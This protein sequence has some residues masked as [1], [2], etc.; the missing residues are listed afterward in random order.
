MFNHCFAK[1][2]IPGS[3]TKGVFTLLKK[4]G[5]HVWKELDYYRPMTLLNTVKDF[6]PG[7][8]EPFAAYR[9]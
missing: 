7:L 1:G 5:R 6:G 8:S 2:T 9:Q 3:I 4:G